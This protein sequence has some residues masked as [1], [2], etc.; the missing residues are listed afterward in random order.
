M[1]WIEKLYRTYEACYGASQFESDPLTPVSHTQ[2]QAHIEVVVDGLGNFQR[3]ALV[4]KQITVIPATEK[5][6]GRTGTRPPPHPLCDK[7][8]YCGADYPMFGGSKTPF[9]FDYVE[10]LRVWARSV[11]NPKVEA[12]L[13][14]VEKGTLV[15]DLIRYNILHCSP[16]GKLLTRWPFESDAPGL[17]K[18]LTPKDGLRDQGDAF[19][20]WR[21]QI[22]GD[23]GSSAVWQDPAVRDAW[24]KFDL[25]QNSGA[26]IQDLCM[27]TGEAAPVAASH[28]QRLRH[29]ADR[30]KL[31]SSNDL[32][33]FTF[34]GRFSRAEQ[35]YG[36]SGVVTQKAHNALRWLIE[37]QGYHDT[38]SGQVYVSWAVS[39]QRTP[40]PLESTA[41]LFGLSGV[42]NEVENL[43]EDGDVGQHFAKRLNSVIAGYGVQLADADEIVLLGLDSATPGRMAVTY[44]R[45][46]SASE[47]LRRLENWH[48][49]YAWF[50]NYSDRLR[51]VGVPA[52]RD[53]A[54]C[55]Y[56]R[57]VDDRLRKATV[58]RLLPCIVDSRPIPRDLVDSCV[59]RVCNRTSFGKKDFWAWEKCLGIVCGLFRGSKIGDTY[60]MALEEDRDTRDYLF[61]RLLAIAEN[62][63]TIALHVAKEKRETN[64]AKLMQRFADHPCSTWRSIELALGPYKSRLRAS[65][66]GA[67]V[68][69]EKLLDEVIGLFR[70]ADFISDGKLTGEFLLGYHCQRAALWNKSGGLGDSSAADDSG[71]EDNDFIDKQ[72]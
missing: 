36:A 35:A 14:Y 58:E 65:R 67:L 31:I 66:S 34:R 11:H 71:R 8:Q 20:R 62:I 17:F 22:Q 7:I 6:A 49:R 70:G 10:Q 60:R 63:E 46:L 69:R 43:Q 27:V 15:G 50:Q 18:M 12:V 5:S 72:D 33:G 32:S 37:R 28:P 25:L 68:K 41:E 56:G 40:E 45:E 54:D 51:F 39:G 1:S 21:V 24:V 2:Q 26:A 9:F 16:D 19:V 29:G 44:Y 23:S 55:A 30:A 57:K 64:A 52:P 53:I 47:F 48:S 4:D 38:K 13:R 3:A 59:R 61:G 42:Q